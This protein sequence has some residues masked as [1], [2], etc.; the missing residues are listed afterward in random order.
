MGDT[1]ERITNMF[2]FLKNGVFSKLTGLVTMVLGGTSAGVWWMEY[3]TPDMITAVDSIIMS[4][5]GLIMM[6]MGKEK[7]PAKKS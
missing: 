2:D 1:Q 6:L 3:M 4:V 7:T 5:V